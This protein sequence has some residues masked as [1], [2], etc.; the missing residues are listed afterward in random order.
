MLKIRGSLLD[1]IS[2]AAV[3]LPKESEEGHPGCEGCWNGLFASELRGS[4]GWVIVISDCS[5][6]VEGTW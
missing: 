6:T 5:S 3:S 2:V 4:R 1:C